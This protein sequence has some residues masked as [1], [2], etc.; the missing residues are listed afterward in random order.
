RFSLSFGK[1][2]SRFSP[3]IHDIKH[4]SPDSFGITK[5]LFISLGATIGCRFSIRLL[6]PCNNEPSEKA[7]FAKRAV[8]ILISLL[9][10][11]RNISM[12]RLE[13]PIIFTGL[14][15]LSV[16]TQKYFFTPF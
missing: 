4:N 10:R 16:E 2:I 6:N 15:A 13:A 14:A 5:Y 3:K 1:K 9:L 12:I 11:I 8:E 7:T